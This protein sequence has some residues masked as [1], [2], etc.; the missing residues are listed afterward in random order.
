[1]NTDI[2]FFFERNIPVEICLEEIF[3]RYRGVGVQYR[4]TEVSTR[5]RETATVSLIVDGH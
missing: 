1:M 4:Y 3:H 5:L 2:D